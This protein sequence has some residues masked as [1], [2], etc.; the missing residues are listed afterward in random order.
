MRELLA[1][2]KVQLRRQTPSGEDSPVVYGPLRLDPSTFELTYGPREIS[3]TVVEGHI[4]R[5][6]MLN[7]GRVVTYARLAEA[8]WGDEDYPGAVVTLRTYIRQLR[9]KLQPSAN[10]AKLILTKP[11]VGYSLVKLA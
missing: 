8:V 9:Q 2:V 11:S 6:L 10:D 1:R 7:A 3:L 4:L 5:Q